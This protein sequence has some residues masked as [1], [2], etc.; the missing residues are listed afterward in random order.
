[1]SFFTSQD[2]VNLLLAGEGQGWLPPLAHVS[3]HPLWTFIGLQSKP[4][5]DF[6][7]LTS[8]DRKEATPPTELVMSYPL[9]S[10]CAQV[11]APSLQTSIEG[12][13][14]DRFELKLQWMREVV[15]LASDWSL[16]LP[17]R[18]LLP[19]SHWAGICTSSYVLSVLDYILRQV[20]YGTPGLPED[21]L[22]WGMD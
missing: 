22:G 6:S 17:G 19:G 10:H 4:L 14:C 7:H 3:S 1:M 9:P 8:Q 12:H 2:L 15:S 5:K 11:Y 18:L 21:R 13:L 16:V 20:L